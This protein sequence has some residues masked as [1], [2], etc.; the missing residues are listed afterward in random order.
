MEIAPDTFGDDG[1]QAELQIGSPAKW[2]EEEIP[3]ALNGGRNGIRGRD[4]EHG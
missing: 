2:P 1:D 3:G 4:R